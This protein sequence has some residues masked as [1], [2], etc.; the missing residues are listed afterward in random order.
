MAI[1][2]HN[3]NENKWEPLKDFEKQIL[4]RSLERIDSCED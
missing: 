2:W 4:D 3:M 1:D